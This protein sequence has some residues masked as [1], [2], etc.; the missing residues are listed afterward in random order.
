MKNLKDRQ[1][2]EKEEIRISIYIDQ[3]KLRPWFGKI[4]STDAI[5]ISYIVYWRKS[6]RAETRYSK[7]GEYIWID[8]KTLLR[9]LPILNIGYEALKDR[10][11]NL[12]SIGVFDRKVLRHA[13]GNHA[14]FYLVPDKFLKKDKKVKGN[15]K[16]GNK[17]RKTK[18]LTA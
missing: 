8:Y 11:D 4:D 5:I 17:Q 6:E 7:N 12:Y 1:P 2:T 3:G 9:Q 18:S 10:L 14:T 15:K 13:S 16:T